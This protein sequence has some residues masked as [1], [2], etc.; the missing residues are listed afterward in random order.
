MGKT[1][2]FARFEV[3]AGDPVSPLV[4]HRFEIGAQILYFGDLDHSPGLLSST[5]SRNAA[6]LFGISVSA[7]KPPFVMWQNQTIYEKGSEI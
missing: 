4:H 5:V 1:Y 3:H 7:K 2:Y 6:A